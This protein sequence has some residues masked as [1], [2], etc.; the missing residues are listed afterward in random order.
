[1]DQLRVIFEWFAERKFISFLIFVVLVGSSITASRYFKSQSGQLSDPIQ[2]GKIIDA[3]Y[4]IGTVTANRRFSFN[5]LIGNT[6]E[7]SFVKEGDYV[8]KNAPLIQTSDGG[9]QRAPFDGVINYYPYKSG[10]NTYATTPMMILTDMTDRYIVV[11]MEQQGALR[12]KVGQ[13]AK[14]S[15]DSIRQTNFEGRVSSVYSYSS[16]FL[17]RVDINDLPLFILPDMTCDVAIVIGEHENVLL[18]PVVAFENGTVWVKHESQLP[19][20]IPIKIGIT[21]GVWAEVL[22]GDL[23]AGDRV[24]TRKQVLQ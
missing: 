13:V 18:I 11:S 23:Q 17:A 15:F 22:E 24:L 4:G 3:I 21:D 7:K 6:V 20:Q 9:I 8:K 16:N 2:K 5:P 19:R 1:M 12:V 10:E 14:I